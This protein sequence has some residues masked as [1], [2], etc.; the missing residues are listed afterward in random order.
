MKF[1]ME[2][3]FPKAQKVPL[4]V[5]KQDLCGKTIVITGGNA[6]IG[7]QCA[8]EF[9]TMN[10]SKIILACRTMTTAEK[11]VDF[12]KNEIAFKI[13]KA[14]AKRYNESG[15]DLH[16]LLANAGILPFG[17]EKLELT[18]DGNELETN[19]L[20]AALLTLSLLPVIRRTAAKSSPGNL[21]RIVIVASDV[22]YWTEFKVSRESGNIMKNM[23]TPESYESP[24]ER[25]KDTKLLN[26]FFAEELANKLRDSKVSEDRKIVVSSCN[27]GLVLSSFAAD[28]TT[29]LPRILENARNLVEGC[30][31]HLF[32]SIDPSAGVPGKANFYHN[33]APTEPSD[34]TLGE[35]GDVLRKRTWNDTLETLHVKE[36]DFDL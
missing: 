8:K 29:L 7:L 22:H 18:A 32:A 30:K 26:I 13:V 9:A 1:S 24:F 15:L 11:A 20:S 25:Y 14:F 5:E 28:L 19:H 23:T 33:C 12:I 35:E 3:D 21:P 4:H 16:L 17:T 10:P 27:P 6:G 34:I 31:T 2:T 36:Q